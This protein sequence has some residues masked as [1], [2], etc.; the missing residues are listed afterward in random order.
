MKHLK[1]ALEALSVTNKTYSLLQAR[2]HLDNARRQVQHLKVNDGI[3]TTAMICE[4]D[5]LSI[6][7]S[8]EQT[9][10]LQ[11]SLSDS[12]SLGYPNTDKR[13][14]NTTCSRVIMTKS[15]VFR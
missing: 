9:I 1:E 15:E 13:V 12:I 2:I 14:E 11:M 4:A 7:P 5:V 10:V 8:L 6:S 3:L